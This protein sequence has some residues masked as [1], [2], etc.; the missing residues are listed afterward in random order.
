[1]MKKSVIVLVACLFVLLFAGC[2]TSDSVST[3][4]KT[5]SSDTVVSASEQ[6]ESSEGE[7]NDVSEDALV[8]TYKV[9]SKEVYIDVP[10]YRE[11]EN[12]YA[13]VFFGPDFKYVA[14]E[15]ERSFDGKVSDVTEA[16]K[17]CIDGFLFDMECYLVRGYSANK[18]EIV[19][20]NGMDMVYFEGTVH[21]GD[22]PKYDVY[23]V[24][25]SFLMDGMPCQIFG[26]FSD[27]NHNPEDEAELKALVTEMAKTVRNHE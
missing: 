25:Y 21:C 11:E 20:V 24:G 17:V 19:T 6:A 16:H 3:D 1:M 8:S 7:K 15:S 26:S 2:D 14:I 22:N 27:E 9:P 23:G 13:E 18:E 5:I 4:D 12:A 10:G